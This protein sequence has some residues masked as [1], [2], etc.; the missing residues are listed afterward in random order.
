MLQKNEWWE[1]ITTYNESIFSLQWIGL[2]ALLCI[3]AYMMFGEEK[4]QIL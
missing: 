1:V 3:T 2:L 4:K